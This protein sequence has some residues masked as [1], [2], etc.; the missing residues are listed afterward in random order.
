MLNA[1]SLDLSSSQD[2]LRFRLEEVFWHFVLEVGV[3][4]AK[5]ERLLPIVLICKDTQNLSYDR[6]GRAPSLNSNA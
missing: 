3:H 4:T 6:S 1:C 2:F 5:P